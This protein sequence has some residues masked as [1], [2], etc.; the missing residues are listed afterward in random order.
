MIRTR[1]DTKL[2]FYGEANW[3]QPDTPV[4]TSYGGAI[5]IKF[6]TTIAA[7]YSTISGHL[8][9]KTKELQFKP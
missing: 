5:V 2:K 1:V 8:S 7:R 3:N 4:S 9:V 6:S